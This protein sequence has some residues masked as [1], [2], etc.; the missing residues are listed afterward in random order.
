V[1]FDG[2]TAKITPRT[3]PISFS[4]SAVG[5]RKQS[6]E[7]EAREEDLSF[8]DVGGLWKNLLAGESAQCHLFFDVTNI[9][10]DLCCLRSRPVFRRSPRQRANQASARV[11]TRHAG[12]RAPQWIQHS[13]RASQKLSGIEDGILRAGW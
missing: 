5:E 3:W 6:H 13:V 9:L 4:Y 11:P 12:V 8:S 1:T 2:A 7:R 10:K